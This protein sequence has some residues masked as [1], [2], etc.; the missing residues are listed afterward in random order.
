MASFV[1][2]D[3]HGCNNTLKHLVEHQIGLSKTDVLYC[4][5]DF[6]DRGPGSRQ[7]L[8]YVMN[9]RE[10]GFTVYTLLGNHEEMFLNCFF[11][12][13]MQGI[14]Y[15]S[16]GNEMLKSFGVSAVQEI[17]EKYIRFITDM[18]RFKV[19]PDYLLV[20]AGF[21]FEINDIFSDE[22]S[23]LWIRN[24]K[25]DPA[26]TGNRIVVHG[27]TPTELKKIVHGI[28]TVS[29]HY[30]INIDNGAVYPDRPGTGNLIAMRLNDHKLFI[31]PN[32]EV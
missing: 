10:S 23:M 4:L 30:Q 17:P 26:K 11:E 31:Q 29:D 22:F 2:S 5:G 18:E 13:S 6:I 25:V 7:V 3:I 12:Q 19:L 16:G 9:L 27:H 21:N 8:D 20:H 15:S 24:S 28:A 32:M 14:W 1:I